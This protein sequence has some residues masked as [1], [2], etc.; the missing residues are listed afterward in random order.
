MSQSFP[1]T[2]MHGIGNDFV[3]LDGIHDELPPIEP[4]AA[5]ICDRR[6]GIGCDQLLVVRPSRTAD[7]RMEIYNRDG[8]PA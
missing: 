7:F 2:K 8:S 4:L 3:V 5:R 1:F 6:F